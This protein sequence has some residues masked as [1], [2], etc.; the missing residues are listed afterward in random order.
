MLC[1]NGTIQFIDSFSK[2]GC[3]FFHGAILKRKLY[4]FAST[5][6]MMIVNVRQDVMM[7]F[8]K[9]AIVVLPGFDT[10]GIQ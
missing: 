6:M 7:P 2:V 1:R 5:G 9:N 8:D 10:V 4:L 3:Q